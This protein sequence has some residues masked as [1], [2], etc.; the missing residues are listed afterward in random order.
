MRC[1]LCRGS[2]ALQNNTVGR[3]LAPAVSTAAP[4]SGHPEVRCIISS[5][6]PIFASQILE[7]RVKTLPYIGLGVTFLFSMKKAA[8]K[9]QCH[10]V[11]KHCH[12][13]AA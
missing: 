4:T 7:G 13:E 12:S 2:F 8:T 10:S 1:H 5:G 3:G 6:N 9:V 11:K